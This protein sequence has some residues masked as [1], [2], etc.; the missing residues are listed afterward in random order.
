VTFTKEEI[1]K[2]EEDHAKLNAK[3]KKQK[4]WFSVAFWTFLIMC[5]SSS[6]F[7]VYRQYTNTKLYF[8]GP[9]Q[10]FL[11]G[12]IMIVL[13]RMRYVIKKT[14][15]LLI[16]E[17]NFIIHELIFLVYT[18]LWT[19]HTI[20]TNKQDAAWEAWKKPESGEITLEGE[21]KFYTALERRHK[22]QVVYLP[23]LLFLNTYILW[24]LH[25]FSTSKRTKFDPVT[26]QEI[27]NLMMFQ[28]VETMESCVNDAA[29]SQMAR[30]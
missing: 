23:M 18:F 9:M 29:R 22:T 13:F 6:Y 14:P 3:I 20:F 12:V 2:H 17:V 5:L 21:L 25:K 7:F 16:S 15:N 26:K 10:Y 1:K 28:S 8:F 27:P 4:T 24:K 11:N 19:I 30:T